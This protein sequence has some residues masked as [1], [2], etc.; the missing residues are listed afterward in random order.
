MPNENKQAQPW[1]F[2]AVGNIRQRIIQNLPPAHP[3]IYWCANVYQALARALNLRRQNENAIFCIV[4]DCLSPDEMQIFPSLSPM[5]HITTIA[6]SV[7]PIQAKMKLAKLLGAH[8]TTTLNNLTSALIAQPKPTINTKSDFPLT[9][10]NSEIDNLLENTLADITKKALE[11]KNHS[12]PIP[13]PPTEST[14]SPPPPEPQK[15]A[16]PIAIRESKVTRRPP[17]PENENHQ[18]LLTQEEIDALLG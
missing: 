17:Q 9:E 7:M 2:V 12:Q 3:D 4:I 13:Q 16:E 8:Q 14:A 15:K 10:K 1:V 11:P 6:L 5:E 18:P